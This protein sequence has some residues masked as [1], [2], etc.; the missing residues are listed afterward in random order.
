MKLPV[1]LKTGKRWTWPEL[2]GTTIGM[3][4]YEGAGLLLKTSIV[5]LTLKLWGVA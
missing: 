2:I 4:L 1:N 3:Y 5:V